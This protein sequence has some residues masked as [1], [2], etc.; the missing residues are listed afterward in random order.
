MHNLIVFDIDGTLIHLCKDENAAYLETVYAVLG[1]RVD[2]DT[3]WDQYKHSTDA[4]VFS[5]VIEKHLQRAPTDAEK[6]LAQSYFFNLLKNYTVNNPT[7]YKPIEGAVG[8]FDKI[9]AA[10]WDV[11]IAT[12]GWQNPAQHKL[13]NAQI[14]NQTIPAA[15]SNDSYHRSEIIEIAID[16]SQA[17]Y[18]KTYYSNVIYVGDRMWDLHAAETLGI[19]FIGVGKHWDNEELE[20]RALFKVHDYNTHDLPAFLKALTQRVLS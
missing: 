10:G 19:G 2:I 5:E 13:Q 11:A 18:D 1:K 4:G 14:H 6:N 9:K 15:S 16:K 20:G 12:G 3:N 17:A 8:L 7:E